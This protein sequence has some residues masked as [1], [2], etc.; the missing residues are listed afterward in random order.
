M[1]EHTLRIVLGDVSVAYHPILARVMG[2]VSGGIWLGQILHWDS[3]KL[4][5]AQDR[6][7]DW[8]GWFYKSEP[9]IICETALTRRECQSA[10]A[11]AKEQGIVQCEVK[12]MPPTSWYKINFDV[13]ETLIEQGRREG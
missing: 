11:F 3:V 4:Q 12:G 5:D 2:D 1:S 10:K 13:L 6:G 9:E 7:I 8:D